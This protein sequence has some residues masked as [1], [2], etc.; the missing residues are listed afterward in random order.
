MPETLTHS[1]ETITQPQ[2]DAQLRSAAERVSDQMYEPEFHE[3]LTKAGI[4]LDDPDPSAY[5]QKMAEYTARQTGSGSELAPLEK[6]TTQL[7]GYLPN[8]LFQKYQLAH[9]DGL[10]SDTEVRSAKRTACTYNNLLKD[11]VRKY[12][13]SHDH[14]KASLLEGVLQTIGGDSLDFS[15]YA[16]KTLDETLRGV[17]HEVGFGAIL[18]S[19]GV[20][21]RDAN[22]SEDLK[23]RD[24]VVTFNGYEVGVD[25]KASLDQVDGKNRGSNGSPIAHKPNGDLVMFSMLLDKDFGDAFTPSEA[26]LTEIAPMTGALL[27]KALMQAIAK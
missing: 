25:V 2:L 10:L 17:K 7:I 15:A 19:L 27:Q 1:P 13:Q 9:H 18:D 26:R 5:W 8:F 14:L 4:D 21:Y 24:L 20:P 16:D 12:P 6:E 3:A 22:I 11:F 23:G